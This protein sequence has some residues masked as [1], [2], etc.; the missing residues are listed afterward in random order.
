MQNELFRDEIAVEI[1]RLVRKGRQDDGDRAKL[2]H[3]ERE[4]IA[5]TGGGC[6]HDDGNQT[7][8][9]GDAPD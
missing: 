7:G 6:G 4:P 2:Q 8:Q 3:M 9:P 1:E 5:S